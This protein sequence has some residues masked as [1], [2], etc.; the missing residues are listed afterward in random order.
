MLPLAARRTQ[1]CSEGPAHGPSGLWLTVPIHFHVNPDYEDTTL[2]S[3]Q[4]VKD[5]RYIDVFDCSI[6]AI[7]EGTKEQRDHGD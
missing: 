7:D 6:H 3:V 4:L 1:S 5:A 2:I